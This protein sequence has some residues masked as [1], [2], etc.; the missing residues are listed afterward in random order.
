MESF[1]DVDRGECGYFTVYEEG[2][3]G[4]HHSF[5]GSGDASR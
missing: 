1:T 5:N 4:E 2:Q 3:S